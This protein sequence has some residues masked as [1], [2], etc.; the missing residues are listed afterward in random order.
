M[1]KKYI[2][3]YLF[4][5]EIQILSDMTVLEVF[6]DTSI[7]TTNSMENPGGKRN[8]STVILLSFR[9]IGT[10]LVDIFHQFSDMTDV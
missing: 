6:Y 7:A 1:L 2:K 3:G 9:P 8:I 10:S 4:S 5:L